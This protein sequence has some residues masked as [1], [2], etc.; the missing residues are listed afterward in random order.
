MVAEMPSET[1]PGFTPKIHRNRTPSDLKNHDFALEGHQFLWNPRISK[2]SPFLLHFRGILEL[3]GHNFLLFYV[4]FKGSRTCV[5][6]HCKKYSKSAPRAPPGGQKRSQNPPKI[7]K[8]RTLLPNST[9]R[10]SRDASGHPW[11]SKMEPRDLKS[12]HLGPQKWAFYV[13]FQSFLLYQN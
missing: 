12:D 8:N 13:D 10:A 4:T 6:K 9:P 1:D 7:I 3:F 2:R 11:A 5:E